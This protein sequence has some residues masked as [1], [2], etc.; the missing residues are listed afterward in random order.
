MQAKPSDPAATAPAET[1][2]LGGDRLGG[3]LWIAFGVAVVVAAWRTDRMA[4]QGV[5]WFGAPGLMPGLLGLAIVLGGLLLTLR[6]FRAPR[7]PAAEALDWP[8]L[9]VTLLLSLGFAG[10]VLGHGPSFGVAAGLYLFIHVAFLQWPE[11]R[12]AGQT[13]R[14]LA[15]A[16]A[17]A[18]GGG[19]LI[20]LVFEQIFLVRLP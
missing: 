13:L 11:R 1:A 2:R 3:P 16:A 19:V 17:V 18:V 9:S 6:A 15:V 10:L 14:G 5:P 7:E 4:A 20:P 8:V 12:A